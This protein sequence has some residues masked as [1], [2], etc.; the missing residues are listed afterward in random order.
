LNNYNLESLIQDTTNDVTNLDINVGI[1]SRHI[2]LSDEHVKILFPAGLTNFRDLTQPGQYACNEKVE[3]IGKKGTIKN[4]RVLGPTRDATQVEISKTD[5]YS[6]GIDPPIKMSGDLDGTPGIT[7]RSEFGE[8]TL[9]QG[10]IIAKRHIHMH[11]KDADKIGVSDKEDVWV[12]ANTERRS[13]IGDATVR[14]KESYAL[15]FHIDT[16]EANAFWLA[17]GQKVRIVRMNK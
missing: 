14:V 15:D 1:S 13:I 5:S 6:L 17:N 12:I 4:V 7:L 11:P 9:N 3:L 16:D 10:L 8:V 2:H